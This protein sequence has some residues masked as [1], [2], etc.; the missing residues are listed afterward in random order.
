MGGDIRRPQ[1][2]RVKDPVLGLQHPTKI[3]IHPGVLIPVYRPWSSPAR[4]CTA[5]EAIASPS[6][7]G[8]IIGQA[9]AFASSLCPLAAYFPATG[10]TGARVREGLD[11][12]QG[13]TGP[14]CR[15]VW[16]VNND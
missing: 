1:L 9:N 6:L 8:W 15:S 5:T 7:S 14:E 10:V 11:D 2:F 13:A 16:P 4:A 3:F 12:E